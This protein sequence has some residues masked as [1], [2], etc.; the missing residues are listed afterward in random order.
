MNPVEGGAVTVE[1][2]AGKSVAAA[3]K[4]VKAAI[5]RNHGRLTASRHSID[6]AAFWF[7]A[8]ERC[9][10]RRRICLIKRYY[11]MTPAGF[12]FIISA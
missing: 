12:F 9:C 11:A 4:G 6:S 10:R 8:L 1:R 7:I 2:D 5:H 3:F